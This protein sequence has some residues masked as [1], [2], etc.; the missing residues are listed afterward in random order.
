MT[1][2]W[3]AERDSHGPGWRIVANEAENIAWC[4]SGLG[5]TAETIERRARLMAAAPGLL[6]AARKVLWAYESNAEQHGAPAMVLLRSA[7]DAA[8]PPAAH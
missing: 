1:E 5:A 6:E 3:T 2:S 7:V 8:D 4:A